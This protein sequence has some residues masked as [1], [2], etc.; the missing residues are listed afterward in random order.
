MMMG[1][2]M[3]PPEIS[4]AAE[5]LDMAM[6]VMSYV[7]AVGFSYVALFIS[8][9]Q[10][11]GVGELFDVFSIFIRALC[12]VILKNIFITLWSLLFVIP[13]LIAA[14]RYS[15]AVFIMLERPDLSIM[16]CLRESKEMTMGSKGKLFLLDL[17]FL[18]WHALSFAV[19]YIFIENHIL[20]TVLTA[21]INVF[22]LPYYQISLA[23]VYNRLC[24]WR[25]QD[26][27]IKSDESSEHL[28]E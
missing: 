15:M 10:K 25:P 2:V 18:L 11:A 8:R 20:A 19:A 1:N 26:E 9:R 23:N 6:S 21:I 16:D 14:Y 28:E 27:T 7:L 12:L 17:S 13:G 22:Y 24:C 3:D 4:P 5:L